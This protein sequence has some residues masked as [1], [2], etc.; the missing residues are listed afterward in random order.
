MF[1]KPKIIYSIYSK[2]NG[3]LKVVDTSS[4]RE[5]RSD[6]DILVSLDEN[7]KFFYQRY[8]GIYLEEVLKLNIK[9]KTVLCFG[10]G[11]GVIQNVL[12]KKFPGIQITTIE[13][14][15]LMNDIHNYYF[16]G[17]K[18]DNHTI[19]NM[20]AKVFLKNYHKFGDYEKYF[21]LI[22]VDI[23]SSMELGEFSKV[24]DF[25]KESKNLLKDTGVYSMNLIVKNH[26]QFEESQK[27]LKV[28]DREFENIKLVY[29]SDFTGIGNLEVF[30]SG[31]ID[32]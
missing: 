14:D 22:F 1:S 17:D 27:C 7:H 24:K 19:L 23:F 15:P 29:T 11:G 20:D 16:S 4:G 26:D 10:L 6:K 8:W 30:A 18:N 21:D 31:K 2:I 12:F 13:I 9:Y 25:Y 32:R 28:L 3:Y 5:L